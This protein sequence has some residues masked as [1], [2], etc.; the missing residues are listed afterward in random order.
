M[1]SQWSDADAAHAVA[2]WGS[3]PGSNADVAMR[4]Y[5]SRLIGREASLVLHGGGNTSVKTTLDDD[6]GTPT[7]VLCVKGSGWGLDDIEPA[8]L[9]AVRLETLSELRRRAA[10]SD[11]AMVN[12]ARIRLLDAAAPNPSVETLLHA[13]LPHTFVDHSHADAILT[14][15]CQPDAEARCRSLF[16]DRLAMVPYVMPGFA[17]AKLAAE[18]YEAHPECEGLLLRNHGLFTFGATARESYER[19]IAAVTTAERAVATAPAPAAPAPTV[20][21]AELA[22]MLRGR[23]QIPAVLTLRD[24]PAP[25]AFADHPA[26]VDRCGRGPMTPDHV[27]RTKPWPMVLDV[28]SRPEAEWPE[29]IEA[30]LAAYRARYI[31]Y[32]E[33]Q[34]GAK[35]VERTM[36][37]PEPRITVVPG[38]GV[39]AAG[40][41]PGAA[42][43]AADLYEHTATVIDDAERLGRYAPLPEADLFD[44]EYWSL[45]QAKLGKRRPAEFAG[46]VVIV[47]GAAAGIGAATVER[48]AAAGAIVVALDREPS[49]EDLTGSG[50][51]L[52]VVVDVRDRAAVDAA[53]TL[54]VEQFGGLDGI[55][56][57]AG[58]AP[59][60]PIADCPPEQL[61]DSLAV[62]LLS[63]QWLAQAA[64]RV[65]VAQGRGGWLLFNASK[66]AFNPG[67]G[68]VPYA[69]A[70]AGLVAL[71]KQYAIEGAPHGIRSNAVNADRV[72]T[73]LLDLADVEARAAARGLS[74]DAY[75]RSNLLGREVT[76]GDVADAFAALARARST[77]GAV[78]PVD[79]GNI[80][81]SPR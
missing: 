72:R 50:A 23:L 55:V 46:Q 44:M 78:L 54:C 66:A 73:G 45:E 32:F 74:A 51:R 33:A 22:P 37:D 3:L 24:G 53:V 43:K 29:R 40:S 61:Q 21:W 52:G 71:M 69:V 15:V 70:K 42:A 79:G 65:L 9:P 49:V 67:A 12:A 64:S 13:F 76:A 63:H 57:N 8:G 75:F 47:T 62:N 2:T 35:K 41:D 48:F 16:G 26:L 18:V 60:S 14:L 28:A 1:K 25:R 56:S 27:I 59:Q 38:L 10:L 77:T 6:T 34:R 4:V 39:V 36:L 11:E 30:A 5:T 20:S 19:H 17:L 7:K 31:A 58:A 81:A 80:A 68:F